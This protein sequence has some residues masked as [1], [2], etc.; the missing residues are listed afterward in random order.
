LCQ[1]ILTCFY[2]ER[3]EELGLRE[4]G[5]SPRVEAIDNLKTSVSA[6]QERRQ[7]VQGPEADPEMCRIVEPLSFGLTRLRNNAHFP[8][9]WPG[10]A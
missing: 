4:I 10:P 8:Q 7:A 6:S 2:A 9:W 1:W 3:E 5:V